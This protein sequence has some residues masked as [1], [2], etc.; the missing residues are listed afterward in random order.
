MGLASR[1]EGGVVPPYSER[2]AAP[3]NVRLL[4]GGPGSVHGFALNQLRLGDAQANPL[5]G[6]RLR[7]AS[8]ERRYSIGLAHLG[9]EVL[10]SAPALRHERCVFPSAHEGNGADA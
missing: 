8:S 4:A 2:D 10:P 1:L 7:T 9:A 3:F 5:G 6:N